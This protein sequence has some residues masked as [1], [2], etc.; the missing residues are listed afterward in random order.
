LIGG[1]GTGSKVQP[2]AIGC[3]HRVL[4][5][6]DTLKVFPGGI[7]A[8]SRQDPEQGL[9]ELP[10]VAHPE[11]RPALAAER[12][13]EE[14]RVCGGQLHGDPIDGHGELV[15]SHVEHDIPGVLAGG[16]DQ[17]A[18]QLGRC[19]GCDESAVGR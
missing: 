11:E 2:V 12:G 17:V 6:E 1:D 19:T 8:R 9:L 14:L 10:G 13:G 7:G 16:F 5:E 15:A 3:D 18:E 4:V